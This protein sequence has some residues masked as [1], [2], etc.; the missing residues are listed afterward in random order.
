MKKHDNIF[1]L[2]TANPGK[3]REMQ[4][5]LS[6]LN[7][8]A[9]TREDFGID[10]EIEETGTTFLENATL[11]A[12][13]ICKISK[14]PSIADDSGLIVDALDGK[15]G[16]YS[17]SFGGE[18]LTAAE[19]CDYLLRQMQN[20][21][22]RQAK[23]VSYIVCAFPDGKLLTETGECKGTITYKPAGNKG[24][25]YDPVF[26]PEGMTKTMAELSSEDKNNI[27][28]RGKALNRFYKLLKSNSEDI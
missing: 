27:S 1:I 16:V 25:G 24:F 12:E 17:S 23:F 3:I 26:L 11:K 28:H 15:P 18:K 2:A 19:R 14:L 9:I 10:I 22:Q 6:K 20:K 8:T 7:I 21:E 4:T 5:L 13:A